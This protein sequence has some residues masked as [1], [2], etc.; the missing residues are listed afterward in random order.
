MERPTKL[1]VDLSKPKG[2]RESIVELTDEEI[3]QSEALAAESEALRLEQEKA[4]AE[5]AAAK[6]SAEAKL[7]ALGLTSEE[8]TA[9]LGV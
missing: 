1:V 3:A 6:V 7:T 9:I 2:Q 8:I 5:K 4:E